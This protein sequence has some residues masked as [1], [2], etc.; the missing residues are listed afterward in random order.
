LFLFLFS[1]QPPKTPKSD[2]GQGSRA[3]DAGLSQIHEED[4]TEDDEDDVQSQ[5]TESSAPIL[6]TAQYSRYVRSLIKLL[7]GETTLNDWIRKGQA[8]EYTES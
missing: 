5:F 7:V 2:R 1:D 4:V 3:G 6:T 8:V